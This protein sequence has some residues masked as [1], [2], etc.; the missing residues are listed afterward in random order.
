MN[1]RKE[2]AENIIFTIN[3]IHDKFHNDY[4]ATTHT[5]TSL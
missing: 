2:Q 3:N 1:P 5:L 4:A